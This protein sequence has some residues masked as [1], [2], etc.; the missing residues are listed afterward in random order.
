MKDGCLWKMRGGLTDLYIED[1]ELSL[2]GFSLYYRDWLCRK[3]QA[4]DE[5]IVQI[6]KEEDL[7]QEQLYLRAEKNAL[8]RKIIEA[9]KIR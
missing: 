5:K 8:R 3:E 9:L 2:K 7:R 6:Q 4:F 1:G